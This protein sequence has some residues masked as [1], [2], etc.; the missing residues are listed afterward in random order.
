MVAVGGG[1]AAATV[2]ALLA[3]VSYRNNESEAFFV[4]SGMF[5][6]VFLC[7]VLAAANAFWP[8]KNKVFASRSNSKPSGNNNESEAD[9]RRRHRRFPVGIEA[10]LFDSTFQCQFDCII[11][12]NSTG[13]AQI[14]LHDAHSPTDPLP[15]VLLLY[16]IWNSAIN[17]CEV[18][19]RNDD[20]V[21]LQFD[22]HGFAGAEREQALRECRSIVDRRR[23]RRSPVGVDAVLAD[24]S[25]QYLVDC[26]IVE[27]SMGGAR[28]LLRG[29][30]SLLDSLPKALLLCDVSNS[31][32][33]KCEVRWRRDNNLGLQ[34]DPHGLP[35]IEHERAII[36]C[37]SFIVSKKDR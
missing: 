24:S 17:K 5:L 35:S 31:V 26:T 2:A 16:D 22:P 14:V 23:D 32:V 34:F 7:A 30:D 21:G 10:I 37:R 6:L 8:G 27:N 29:P 20:A 18:R 13:G 4:F 9:N 12:D 19:W 28:V 25:F 36:E 15:D 3:L 1:V 11:I 33:N